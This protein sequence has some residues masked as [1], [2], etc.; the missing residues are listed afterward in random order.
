MI[1]EDKQEMV[2]ETEYYDLLG[3][4][5]TAT[6]V[7]IKKA[8]YIKVKTFINLLTSKFLCFGMFGC[9]NLVKETF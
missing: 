4:S 9:H 2:M 6:E 5:L 1:R 7:E 8:Y 3:V